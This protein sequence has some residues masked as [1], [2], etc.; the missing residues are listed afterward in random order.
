MGEWER[1]RKQ[2]K[3]MEAW[4]ANDL[5]KGEFYLRSEGHGRPNCSLNH[6]FA[7]GA[8]STV[9]YWARNR[10]TKLFTIYSLYF[11]QSVPIAKH[12]GIQ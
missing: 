4:G 1:T 8:F 5:R 3:E 11:H 9:A 2:T 6:I 7:L 10:G 12:F